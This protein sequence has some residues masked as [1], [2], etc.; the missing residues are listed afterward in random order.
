M[1]FGKFEEISMTFEVLKN[2]NYIF[3]LRKRPSH[4]YTS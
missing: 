3:S 1:S 2:A 4:C